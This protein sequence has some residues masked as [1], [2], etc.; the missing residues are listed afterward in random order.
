MLRTPSITDYIRALENPDGIFKTL[1]DVRADRD[2]YREIALRAGNSA[3]VFTFVRGGAK[4]L[5]KCHIRPNPRLREIYDYIETRRPPLLPDVRLLRD[6]FYVHR[7]SGGE[8]WVD[9]VEGEWVEGETL[10]AA[11]AHAAK[12][13][14]AQGL[15]QLAE[16]FDGMCRTL[17]GQEWA[18][19]DLK[20]ENIVVRGDGA[21]TLIDCDAI[22]IPA[23]TGQR[24]AELG[25][26][27]YCH[28][29]RCALC[30]DKCIDDYSMLLISVSLHALAAEPELY[31]EFSTPDNM[32]MHPVEITECRSAACL[33]IA[34]IFARRGMARE[35]AMLE[36]CSLPRAGDADARRFFTSRE[37]CGHSCG[38]LSVVGH[39]GKWGF[40]NDAGNYPSPPFWDEALGF[41]NGLAAVRLKGWWHMLDVNGNIVAAGLSYDEMCEKRR[42][43]A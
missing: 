34:E 35:L 14:D 43:I 23:F 15:W 39:S 8:G 16:T 29:E 22:W 11:V 37:I 33:R 6:E 13:G 28:P 42:K 18:H 4:H 36:M 31:A 9:V 3:A 26:P 25:T 40:I 12:A 38:P 17:L 21:F 20:P 2:I 7:L 30:F 32:L 41:R 1:G 10:D 27:G 5:L 19:G 24:A